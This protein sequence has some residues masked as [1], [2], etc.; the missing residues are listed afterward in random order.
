MGLSD[1]G[2]YPRDA[3]AVSRDMEAML[4]AAGIKGPYV[5]VGHSLGSF[6]VRQFA[7]THAREVVGMVLVDPSGDFQADHFAAASPHF[8]SV[9]NPDAQLQTL[10][11]CATR[12]RKGLVLHGT[13]EFRACGG[14][15][16]ARFETLASEIESMTTLSSPELAASRRSYGAMP[17]IVL[18]RGDFTKGMPADAT[19]DDTAAFQKV[20]RQ[21]HEEM[22]ALSSVG[23]RREIAN[24]SHYVQLDQP[25]AVIDA[26]NEVIDAARRRKTPAH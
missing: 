12:T 4:K 5:L 15:T 3:A 14:N 1:P 11:D 18:T 26:V 6:H 13:A 20:W 2:P 22:R 24:S 23:E 9:T 17:L 7:N 19:P 16:A 21:M 8:A 25:A 10:K